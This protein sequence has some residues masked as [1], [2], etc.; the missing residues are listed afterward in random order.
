MK[1]I[2]VEFERELI[3]YRIADDNNLKGEEDKGLR[4]LFG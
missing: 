2:L 4:S 3:Q 1:Y